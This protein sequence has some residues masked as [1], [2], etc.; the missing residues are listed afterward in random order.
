M[1]A[2]GWHGEDASGEYRRLRARLERAL[3]SICP[4]NLAGHVDD[5]AQ[6]AV[7]R[8]MNLSRQ[9][10][11]SREFNSSYIRRVAYSV[12]VDEIRKHRRR[13]E[14]AVEKHESASALQSHAPDPEELAAG[15]EIGSA[16]RDCLKQ[17]IAN[18]RRAVALYL[19]GHRV[20]EVA[21][22]LDWGAKRA[23]NLVFRGMADL[24]NCLS[25]KGIQP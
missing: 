25:Q 19:Q 24:R 9:R 4:R 18:R 17:M 7:M 5:L 20:P 8:V 11:G 23:E 22:L 14:E 3:L 13:R 15:R 16:I 21:R 2:P 10:E 12:L 6:A 1:N